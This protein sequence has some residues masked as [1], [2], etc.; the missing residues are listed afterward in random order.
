MK[1]LIFG[2]IWLCIGTVVAFRDP[3][4]WAERLLAALFWPFFIISTPP[5]VGPP[6]HAPLER[7]RQ[8]MGEGDAAEALLGELERTVARLRARVERLSQAAEKVAGGPSEDSAMGRAR[9]D[10]ERLLQEARAKARLE[11]EA[12]LV[13]IDDAATRLVIAREAGQPGEVAALL[14][15]LRQRLLAEAEVDAAK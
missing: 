15:A 13:A 11:L 6:T 3:R 1:A 7:L 12:A 14:A 2:A 8:A 4:P 5:P 9:G 10:S